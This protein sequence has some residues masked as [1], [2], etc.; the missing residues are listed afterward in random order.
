LK[1][2]VILNNLEQITSAIPSYEITNEMNEQF[3]VDV[4]DVF[5]KLEAP[6]LQRTKFLWSE[7]IQ[8]AKKTLFSKPM[9]FTYITLTVFIVTFRL[10]N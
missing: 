5:E 4:S 10:I 2:Q 8:N 9:Y 6:S 7:V 1:R 3:A